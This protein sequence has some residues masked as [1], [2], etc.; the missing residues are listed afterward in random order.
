MV[1]RGKKGTIALAGRDMIA[2]RESEEHSRIKVSSIKSKG[3]APFLSSNRISWNANLT[4]LT[5]EMEKEKGAKRPFEVAKAYAK[6][7]KKV[8]QSDLEKGGE[9]LTK[10]KEAV[11][12]K[13]VGSYH[14]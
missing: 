14:F 7:R 6:V 5:S 9:L 4:S 8:H 3:L 2:E 11:G 1:S 13:E 12:M 10:A